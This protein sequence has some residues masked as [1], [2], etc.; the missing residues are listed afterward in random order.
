MIYEYEI[1]TDLKK[2]ENFIHE[3]KWLIFDY[4][5]VFKNYFSIIHISVNILLKV[6]KYKTESNNEKLLRRRIVENMIKTVDLINLKHFKD[7]DKC[8]RSILEAFFKFSLECERISIHKSN[9]KKGIYVAT[10]KLKELKSMSNTQKIGRLTSYW[11]EHF[12]DS[13]DKT[14]DLYN[15]YSILSES[16]HISYDKDAPLDIKK[17][18][19][20]SS[21]EIL[22]EI[23]KYIGILNIISLKCLEI[24]E[25]LYK[26]KLMT[27]EEQIYFEKLLNF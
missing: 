13:F 14:D 7:V 25:G 20:I 27:T 24:L 12:K 23:D 8:Y 2:Y 18:E 5:E 4:P 21:S 19:D 9:I 10:P 15:M 17:Y 3:R 1:I 16:V 26:T 22:D 6:E 11:R